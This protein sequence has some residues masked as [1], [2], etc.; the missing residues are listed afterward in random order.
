MPW[1]SLG[2]VRARPHPARGSS[3]AARPHRSSLLASP[4]VRIFPVGSV[5]LPFVVSLS[6][7]RD[8]LLGTRLTGGGAHG[9]GVRRASRELGFGEGPEQEARRQ[10]YAQDGDEGD[11][12]A[13][14]G[15]E[16]PAREHRGDRGQEAVHHGDP[17][18]EGGEAGAAEEVPDQRP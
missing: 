15:I 17:T 12:V 4:F 6:N 7:H 14:G 3:K 8:R 13:V 18:P 5:L 16:H 1:R 11:G 9:R 2:W 10:I